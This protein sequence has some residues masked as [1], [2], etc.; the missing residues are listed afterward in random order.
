MVVVVVFASLPC[1]AADSTVATSVSGPTVVGFFPPVSQKEIEDDTSGAREGIAHVRFSLED[2]VSCLA[3]R[4]I[5]T[6]LEFTHSLTIKDGRTRR[7]LTFPHD[8]A[9][10]VG[11]VLVA[12]GKAPVVVYATGGPSSLLELAPQAAWKYFNEPKCKRYEE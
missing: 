8:W 7:R 11:V 6:R 5:T 4:A 1:I 12:P 10:S 9:H 2:V 3:P